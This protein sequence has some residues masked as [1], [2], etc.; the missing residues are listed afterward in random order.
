MGLEE[1]GLH[2][3]IELIILV[4]RRQQKLE[5]LQHDRLQL[6]QN[7]HVFF[8]EGVHFIAVEDLVDRRLGTQLAEYRELEASRIL[9]VLFV[10]KYQ[11]CGLVLLHKRLEIVL[12]RFQ[13]FEV[14]VVEIDDSRRHLVV[15]ELNRVH[16]IQQL[17]LGPVRV[18]R[19]NLGLDDLDV[20]L[21]VHLHDARLQVFCPCDRTRLDLSG[22]RAELELEFLNLDSV[23]QKWEDKRELEVHD[24][25]SIDLLEEVGGPPE[26]QLTLGHYGLPLRLLRIY[27]FTRR[28]ANLPVLVEIEGLNHEIVVEVEDLAGVM[29]HLL[30]L[31]ADD[32]EEY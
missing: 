3:R 5:I 28:Y 31:L 20:L 26:L 13:A 12:V 30:K 2:L 18:P 1:A 15:V 19:I 27:E 7:L 25:G 32:Q 21:L 29:F 16:H 8:L 24:V 9:L 4:R 6:E 22:G 14:H 23:D 10:A 17:A 11:A